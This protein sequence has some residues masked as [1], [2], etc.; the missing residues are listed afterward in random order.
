[1]ISVYPVFMAYATS[2]TVSRADFFGLNPYELSQKSA[3][4]CARQGP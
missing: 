2:S 1:M 3:S 4:K